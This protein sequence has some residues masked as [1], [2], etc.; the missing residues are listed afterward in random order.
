MTVS[1]DETSSPPFLVF[2]RT[3]TLPKRVACETRPVG[4]GSQ[5]RRKRLRLGHG[6]RINR[7]G[8]GLLATLRA[9]TPVFSPTVSRPV[10]ASARPSAYRCRNDGP[11]ESGGH[12]AIAELAARPCT[13][14]RVFA[15]ENNTESDFVGDY[16]SQAREKARPR[17][18]IPRIRRNRLVIRRIVNCATDVV[19]NLYELFSEPVFAI[20]VALALI[21][22]AAYAVGLP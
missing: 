5:R 16:T 4:G 13:A 3:M 1:I 21:L 17:L 6:S 8:S 9:R 12:H 10:T 15:R 11:R 19:M 2:E 7:L 14:P 22:S 18:I 20:G